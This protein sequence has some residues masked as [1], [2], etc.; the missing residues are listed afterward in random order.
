[1]FSELAGKDSFDAARVDQFIE[2]VEDMFKD[3]V[4]PFFEKDEIKKVR[5][6]QV[7]RRMDVL[8]TDS[9]VFID[10]TFSYH[11]C[12]RIHSHTMV[13]NTIHIL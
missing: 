3:I 2:L 7:G 1:M 11:M 12:I 10:N 5:F 6:V 13:T 8:K 9:V 4:K